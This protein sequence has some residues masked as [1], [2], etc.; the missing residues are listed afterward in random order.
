M[1]KAT[2]GLDV[3]GAHLKVARV[4]DARVTAVRQIACPLWL[5]LDQLDAALADAQSLIADADICAVTMT[6]ELTEIFETRESGVIQVLERLQSRLSAELRIYMGLKGF[7]APQLAAGD[8]ISV[9]SANFLATAALVARKRR[10]ALL[11]DMGST[12]TD[13]IACERPLGLSDAERLQTG[14]L[15]YTGF[16]RTPVPSVATRAPLAGQW[17]GLARDAFASMAD[18][19]RVLGTLPDDVDQHATTDGRGKSQRESL[20]RFARGF[21]RDADMRQLSTWQ[22]SAA[23]IEERQLRSLHD[24]ALQVLSRPGTSIECVIAAGI[25]ARAAEQI[26]ARLA[27]PTTAFEELIDVAPEHRSWATRCAPAV[28]VALLALK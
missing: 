24:G 19:R 16:T 17:Q 3:G 10:A 4:E 21:G 22:I 1:A 25:G 27:L 20:D 14:E 18:V 9:A 2:I 11:I 28:A 26:G 7:A 15:V 13:I 6:A 5:G 12:T 23:Y 8:P